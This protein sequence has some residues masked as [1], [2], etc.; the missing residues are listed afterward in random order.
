[1][2][3]YPDHIF[4][5]FCKHLQEVNTQRAIRTRSRSELLNE[6]LLAFDGL[7]I[8]IEHAFCYIIGQHAD[9]SF[10]SH[11]VYPDLHAVLSYAILAQTE[12]YFCIL[13]C[14]RCRLSK[15]DRL[16]SVNRISKRIV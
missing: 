3:A 8:D 6:V 12:V 15:D 2:N 10:T 9:R 13:V 16:I 4:S 5:R 1:M 11:F 7:V 14:Y